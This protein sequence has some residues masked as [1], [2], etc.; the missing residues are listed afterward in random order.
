LHIP[1]LCKEVLESLELKPGMTILD[2][3]LG[4]GG[5][6]QEMLKRITPGGKLIAIDQDAEAIENAKERLKD[7]KESLI[8]VNDN[9]KNVGAILKELGIG[10]VNGA[11]FDL[12]VSSEQ[13]GLAERGFAI[14]LEGPLDMR[15]DKSQQLSAYELVNKLHKEELSKIFKEYGEERY[16]ERIAKAI[17]LERHKDPIETTSRLAQIVTRS[18]PKRGFYKIHP[19]TRVFQALRIAVNKELEALEKGIEE[20]VD[21]LEPGAR[22]CVISYHSLED[23]I[24]KNKFKDF[25]KQGK[26]DILTKKP[27]VPEFEEIKS[28]PR[29]RSAK[30]RAAE[31]RQN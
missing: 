25:K 20:T 28:N 13:L 21:S 4:A 14:K 9:F 11:V 23:R 8:I 17:V 3:T 22:I 18:I 7:F 26:I 10:K 1:V 30:L 29:S 27:L 5:H 2:C 6:A 31:R 15:M 19:A 16:H 24:V 12:G